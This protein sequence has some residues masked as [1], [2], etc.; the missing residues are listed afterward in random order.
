MKYKVSFLLI[1]FLIS[2]PLI[3]FPQIEKKSKTDKE[4][5]IRRHLQIF[6]M[7]EMTKALDLT[8]EQ[9]S[10]IFPILNRL[11]KE[12]AELNRRI[13]EKIRDL[14]ELLREEKLN[15]NLIKEKLDKIK[16]LKKQIQK[17][18]SEIEKLL[19]DNLTIEQQAKYILFSIRFMKDLREKINRARQLYRQRM[20]QREKRNKYYPY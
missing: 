9:A 2:S 3:I 14:R 6:R 19:E 8:E 17:I 1:I 10:K 4:E 5:E 7:W 18:D 13:G 16:D 11:E 20:I 15:S 12:K